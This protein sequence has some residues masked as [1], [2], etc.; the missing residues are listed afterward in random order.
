MNDKTIKEIKNIKLFCDNN[1]NFNE[2]P[3][4]MISFDGNKNYAYVTLI[5][6]EDIYIAG[7][8]VLAESIR[9]LGS[10]ADLVVIVTN[11]ISNEGKEILKKFYDKIVEIDYTENGIY[12]LDI[13]FVKCHLFKLIEYKKIIMI[14]ADSLILKYPDHLFTLS[15]PAGIYM[16]NVN[17][18]INIDKN[19]KNNYE[20]IKWYKKYCDCC[21]H[22]KI[23]PKNKIKKENLDKENGINSRLLVLEPSNKEFEFI[24]KEL[25]Q[26]GKNSVKKNISEHEYLNMHYLDKWTSI[27]PIFLAL[28]GLPHWSVV[29]GLSYTDS[30]PFILKNPLSLEER[31][32]IED[33]Q[34]WYKF[35]GE[36]I[37]RYPELLKSNILKDANEISKYFIYSLSRKSFEIKKLLSEGIINSVSKI[38]NVKKQ[39]NYYYY[40]INISKEYDNESVNYLFEDD[41]IQNMIG[42]I[43]KNNNS[44]YWRKILDRIDLK[45]NLIDNYES[46]KVNSKLLKKFKQEDKENILSYYTKINSNV[47]IIIVVTN[48]KNEQNFWLDNNLISNILYQKSINLNGLVLKNILFNINQKYC[49]DERIKILNALYSDVNDYNIKVLLYKTLIDCNLKGNNNDILVLS[50]TNSKIRAL[51]ILFNENTLNKFL[52]R[53]FYFIANDES[54]LI[55]KKLN[56]E[57]IVK[58]NLIYQSLKKWIYNNYDGNEMDNV[59]I[60]SDFN[61]NANILIKK[62]KLL[63]TNIYTELD[64]NILINYGKNKLFFLDIIFINKIS[65]KSKLYKK[66]E[67]VIENIHDSRYYYQIDGIKF[68]L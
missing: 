30:K 31:V 56:N 29:C 18:W 41:F 24:M 61:L 46:N 67:N 17:D 12:E 37:N 63:D 6:I 66:Y 39:K 8:I 13:L 33:F 34:L 4:D 62:I 49:Y 32:K 57:I 1:E 48:I 28:H 52:N 16:E 64:N 3:N 35:Y 53:E 19:E 7:A 58:N 42:D 14:D 20:G 27:N 21:S 22:G 10:L 65:E 36:I 25:D 9:K 44:M 45:N 11:S 40:H 2:M 50:D 51:S 55:K 26:I 43:L 68:S 59:I 47:S 23:I 60:V 38:F 15:T 54:K 5:M